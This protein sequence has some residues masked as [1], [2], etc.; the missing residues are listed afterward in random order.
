MVID[1]FGLTAEQTRE[2]FPEVY[3][4]VFE[5]VKPERDQNN[6]ATY[7]QNWWIFGEPRSNLRP[8]LAGL[9]RY[10]A[11]VET[12]KHRFFVFLDENILPDNRLVN[13][14]L[15]DA[16]YLGVLSSR[17]HVT[18][19]F[20]SGGT[21]EDRPVYTKTR[22]FD[23]FPFPDATDEQKQRIRQLA[24]DLDAHRKRQQAQHP[25]LTITEMYNVL[26]ALRAG[27][28][29]SERERVI[30][31]Q[32]LVSVLKGLHDDLDE[33][34][35]AA[36]GWEP[37]ISDEETLLRLVA[38]NRVRAEEERGG[39][40]R[41]LRPDYQ[42]PQGTAQ[43]ALDM[44]DAEATRPVAAGGSQAKSIFP[45]NLAEQARAVRGALV[46]CSGVVTAAQLAKSFQRARVD[47]IEELLQTLVLLGQA[48]QVEA[49]KYAP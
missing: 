27:Q 8:A 14:A 44:K 32:G 6:R 49:G 40:V 30:N 36:Y 38:L 18:W 41:W 33:A 45:A 22:C 26:A 15:D 24:E 5:H 12:S 9:K 23:P 39:L 1:L 37:A 16:Y 46:S 7:R 31:E 34:V 4:W 28:T 35:C 3:Q 29:L 11:T 20:A 17:V 21:L 2:Q 19:A 13:I 10:I 48:R 43:G 42:H 25:R 47:R